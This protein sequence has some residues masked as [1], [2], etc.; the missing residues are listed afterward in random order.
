LQVCLSG[1]KADKQQPLPLSAFFSGNQHCLFHAYNRRR[2]PQIAPHRRAVCRELLVVRDAIHKIY[3]CGLKFDIRSSV[4]LRARSALSVDSAGL[5]ESRETGHWWRK[6]PVRFHCAQADLLLLRRKP[7]KNC[8][9]TKPRKFRQ[10]RLYQQVPLTGNGW[11]RNLPA[12]NIHIHDTKG[13]ENRTTPQKKAICLPL[14]PTGKTI[15]LVLCLRLW[16]MPGMLCWKQMGHQQ[17]PNLDMPGLRTYPYDGIACY[18][19]PIWRR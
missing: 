1:T 15:L 5:V 2:A 7:S 16:D 19:R 17:R 3:F 8:T 9:A 18:C 14:L 4:G 12:K 10:C 6:S 11:R 13:K